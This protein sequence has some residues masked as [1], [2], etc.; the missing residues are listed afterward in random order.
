MD[1]EQPAAPEGP[2]A[3]TSQGLI[4]RF[5]ADLVD[6]PEIAHDLLA[7]YDQPH[8]HYHDRRH[9]SATLDRI[10]RLVGVRNDPFPVRIAAWFHDAVYAIPPGQVTNEEASAR[11]ALRELSRCGLEEE[12]LNEIARLIRLT[13]THQTTST[14]VDGALLCDADLAIL[15][16][17]EDTYR[18]YVADVRAEH[19]KLSDAEFAHGRLQVLR[20]FG[21]RTIFHTA[22]GREWEPAAQANLVAEAYELIDRLPETVADPDQWPLSRSRPA[23]RSAVHPH[24]GDG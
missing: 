3:T 11:L 8:R 6:Q 18:A 9:L 14:D 4:D 2:A 22:A 21:G 17:P 15:A 23:G 19:P 1:E 7:R 13:E 10:D 12:D 16:A 5:C 20:T 24:L